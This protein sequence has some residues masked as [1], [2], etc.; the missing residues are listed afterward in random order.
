MTTQK[1][2]IRNFIRQTSV[3]KATEMMLFLYPGRGDMRARG[4]INVHSYPRK[5]KTPRAPIVGRGI[6]C[7]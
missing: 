7:S 4:K 6:P 3:K 5:F 2:A 1:Y